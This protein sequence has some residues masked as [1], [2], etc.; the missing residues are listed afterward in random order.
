M[1]NTAYLVNSPE[2]VSET[3]DGELVIMNLESGDYYSA[4][5]LGA[6]I[7]GW[8]EQ[9]F[10]LTDIEVLISAHYSEIDANAESHLSE[11]VLKLLNNK[12]IKEDGSRETSDK[13]SGPEGGLE[14]YQAPEI[15]VYTDMK[16]MLLL[17]PI[18]EVDEVGWPKPNVG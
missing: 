14:K 4:E 10:G 2:V 9:G 16:D 5:A 6:A 17:D 3:I 13:L 1:K 15:T 7:W 18:H 12:L 11:F 8:I